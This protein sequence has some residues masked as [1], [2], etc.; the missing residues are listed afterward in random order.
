MTDCTTPSPHDHA[1]MPALTPHLVID[2]AAAAIAFYREAFGAVELMRLPGPAGRLMH[3]SLRIGDSM[4]MLADEFPGCDATG[5]MKLGGSPVVLHLN[6]DDV[7]AV[8][9]RAV[10]AG[11]TATMPVADMFWGDRYG[12]VTDPFGHRW[13]IGTHQRDMT[14]EEIAAEML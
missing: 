3:V 9:A 1:R 14:V 5:P 11:A 8:F 7:D 6:V 12:Q 4:L 13:S 10:R 2:G